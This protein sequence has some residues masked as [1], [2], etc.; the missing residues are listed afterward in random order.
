M[1]FQLGTSQAVQK[2]A[3]IFLSRTYSDSG[4]FFTTDYQEH[5]R[6]FP[7][8]HWEIFCNL[9][10]VFVYYRCSNMIIDIVVLTNLIWWKKKFNSFNYLKLYFFCWTMI[11]HIDIHSTKSS[12]SKTQTNLSFTCSSYFNFLLRVILLNPWLDNRPMSYTKKEH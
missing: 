9:M 7:W 12:V 3:L 11:P 1:F 5:L 6:S 10:E 2:N 4:I 8:N